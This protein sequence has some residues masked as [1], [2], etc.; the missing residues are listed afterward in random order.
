MTQRRPS[1][2]TRP[3]RLVTDR[4]VV[5]LALEGDAS[6][7]HDFHIR[8]RD[9]LAP[10]L[11]PLA[12]D[13]F[14][15]P[16]WHRWGQASLALFQQDQMARFV[17]RLAD[18]DDPAIGGDRI[19]GQINFANVVRG[20]WQACTVGYHLD[21]DAEGRGLMAE[22]LS[23]TVAYMFEVRRLNRVMANY[24]PD[25]DRS[26]KLL[27]RLGFEKEGYARRYLYI[28]GAWRDHVLT[29]KINPSLETPEIGT[30]PIPPR[31]P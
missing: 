30:V 3:P 4:L 2:L 26:A 15:A 9:F 1:A 27:E 12:P 28:N 22:G 10:W 11:P 19:I 14:T 20:P 31:R 23:A 5:S 13:F 25:N 8:N 6:D 29:S 18:R 16:F 17:L 24:I 7:L 21:R